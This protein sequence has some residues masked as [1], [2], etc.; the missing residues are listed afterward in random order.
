[1]KWKWNIHEQEGR[2]EE[3]LCHRGNRQQEKCLKKQSLST[4]L[5]ISRTSLDV[6]IWDSSAHLTI[7]L[8]N[9]FLK[10]SVTVT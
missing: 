10:T 6:S 5:N 7:V 2:A 1:M 3:G 8:I 4:Y 9:I